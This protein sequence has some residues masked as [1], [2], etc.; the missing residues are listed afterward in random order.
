MKKSLPNSQPDSYDTYIGLYALSWDVCSW[1]MNLEG[2]NY[3]IIHLSVFIPVV[4][5]LT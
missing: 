4:G 5:M 1:E 3:K 2:L